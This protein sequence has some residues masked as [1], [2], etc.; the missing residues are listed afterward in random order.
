MYKLT[1]KHHPRGMQQALM[2]TDELRWERGSD[3]GG[4]KCVLK[5]G[6]EH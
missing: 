2:E 4:E 5:G 6:S 3:R 1:V